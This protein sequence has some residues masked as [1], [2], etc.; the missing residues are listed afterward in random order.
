MKKRRSKESRPNLYPPEKEAPTP[1][2]SSGLIEEFLGPEE[3]KTRKIGDWR[4]NIEEGTWSYED[5]EISIYTSFWR[6]IDMPRSVMAT[7]RWVYPKGSDNNYGTHTKISHEDGDIEDLLR[8][9]GTFV[10]GW[11]GREKDKNDE[12]H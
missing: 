2:E 3:R 10:R 11:V 4:E 6:H 7:I 8:Y 1:K 12:A 9:V 5:D